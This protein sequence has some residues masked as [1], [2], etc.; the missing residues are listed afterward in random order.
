M[1][2]FTNDRPKCLN[3]VGHRPLLAWQISAL[4]SGGAKEIVVVTGYKKEM[5]R[6]FDIKSIHNPNWEKTNMLMS[7]MSAKDQ[8][9]KPILLSYSDILY[10]NEVVSALVADSRDAVVAYD[11]HWNE[12]WE[13]RFE[14]PLS[15]AE[16]FKI[17]ARG[18]ILEIGEKVQNIKEIQGQYMGIMRFS[19]RTLMWICEF[20]SSNEQKAQ[21]MDM[22]TLLRN[23]INSGLDVYGYPI[24]GGWCEID[25][26]SD[27]DLAEQLYSEGKLYLTKTEI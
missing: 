5:F 12:L 7:L 16:S 23:M 4:R 27:L 13:R 17:D 2:E 26:T 14:N 18:R 15:D 21:K 6:S 22:T 8:F 3:E 11:M 25:T 24:Q 19:Q 20:V 1:K 10:G 9:T